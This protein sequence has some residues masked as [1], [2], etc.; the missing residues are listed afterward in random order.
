MRRQIFVSYSGKNIQWLDRL[1][2]FL[3][4][5]ERENELILWKAIDDIEPSTYTYP[6]KLD[7]VL[8]D[9]NAGK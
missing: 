2:T 7:H 9:I 6:Q 5:L 3:R 1:K 4:P 8:S